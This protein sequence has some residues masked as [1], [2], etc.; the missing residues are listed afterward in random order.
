M[1]TMVDN[2]LSEKRKEPK[3]L[4]VWAVLKHI[5]NGVDQK[6]MVQGTEWTAIGVWVEIG[7]WDVIEFHYH[8]TKY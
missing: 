4:N 5:V 3:Q 7:V 1:W 2:S 6:R 8:R